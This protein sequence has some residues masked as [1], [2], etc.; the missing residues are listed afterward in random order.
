MVLASTIS[1]DDS[2]SIEIY[3]QSKSST[4]LDQYEYAM[5]GKIFK[6]IEKD[7]RMYDLLFKL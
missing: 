5:H 2:P 6:I 1:L 3:D 7:S 4:L